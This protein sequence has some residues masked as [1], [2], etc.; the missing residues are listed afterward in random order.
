MIAIYVHNQD[1]F[2]AALENPEHSTH[3]IRIDSPATDRINVLTDSR[4][5]IQAC[6]SSTVE[7]YGSSTVEAHGSAT[8]EAYESA[9]VRAYGSAAVEACGSSTVEACGSATVAAYGSATVKAHGLATVEAY[10]SATVEAYESATV[11]AYE[12]AT[13]EACGS[14]TVKAH[15]SATVRAYGSAT[16]RAY[17]SATVRAYESATVEAHGSATVAAGPFVAVHLF[18]ANV[19]VEGG[20]IID[21]SKIDYTDAE[22]WA[23]YYGAEINGEEVLLYKALSDDLISGKVCGSRVKW[24]TS[25]VVSCDDWK[26]TNEC[27]GGLHLSPHPYQAVAYCGSEA[28]RV[29]LCSAKLEDVFPI[30]TSLHPKCKARSVTV[31]R[32]VALGGGDLEED[33]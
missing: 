21:V 8:V 9:T 30:P 20:V 25:G 3:E 18:S 19:A 27:G 12:S 1:E 4:L 13:V 28:R 2:D 15:G 10:G 29:L 24:P 33:N 14:A 6:G 16:V 31:L 32:E 17:E 26:P 5:G 11:E 23:T 22:Q 7:A